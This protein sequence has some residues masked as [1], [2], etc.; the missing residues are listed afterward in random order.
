MHFAKKCAKEDLFMSLVSG[1]VI[2]P[3][4]SS[5]GGTDPPVHLHPSRT[6]AR[7]CP[8]GTSRDDAGAVERHGGT[9]QKF[10]MTSPQNP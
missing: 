9:A 2:N 4:V 5:Q 7:A 1:C 3:S 6:S 8:S 10:D